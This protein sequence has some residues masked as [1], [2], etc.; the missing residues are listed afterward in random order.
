MIGYISYS[1]IYDIYLF[2]RDVINQI[3]AIFTVSRAVLNSVG[4][5]DTVYWLVDQLYDH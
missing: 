5:T 4:K 1:C 2:Y 3:L